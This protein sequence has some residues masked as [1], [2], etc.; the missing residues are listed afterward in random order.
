MG[1]FAY[2][3]EREKYNFVDTDNW[4]YTEP[5]AV[6][7]WSHGNATGSETH[8]AEYKRTIETINKALGLNITEI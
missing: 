8:Q 1:A 5:K 2:K 3:Y 7:L 6:Q 4:T